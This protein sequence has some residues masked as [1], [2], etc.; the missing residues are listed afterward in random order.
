MQRILY[1]HIFILTIYR[2]AENILTSAED[3]AIAV[4]NRKRY[5]W[6]DTLILGGVI[7]LLKITISYFISPEKA[8]WIL[9]ATLQ[10]W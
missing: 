1:Q 9:S 6:Q 7:W 5:Y 2:E 4:L 3:V 10:T 8:R